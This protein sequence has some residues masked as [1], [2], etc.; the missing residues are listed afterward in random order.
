MLSG[1]IGIQR[2]S[3]NNPISGADNAPQNPLY[4]RVQVETV[5][6]VEP[7]TVDEMNSFLKL[8]G[9]AQNDYVR[10]LIVAARQACETYTGVK[11]VTQTLNAWYDRIP[12]DSTLKLLYGPCQ[13][14]TSVTTYASDGT[15]TVFDEDSYFK[16]IISSS[17][18]IILVD[19]QTWPVNTRS[20]NAVRVVYVVGYGLAANVPEAI[21]TAI[22]LV[23]AAIFETPG[24][25][26]KTK[27]N[28]NEYMTEGIKF[29]LTPYT[30]VSL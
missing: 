29:M 2:Y 19:G 10:G 5:P 13:S 26:K 20:Y 7:V 18:R 28:V 16:D 22:K 8:N 27:I 15:A 14:I 24:E 6:A 30:K 23:V 12:Y 9:E 21:K 17:P 4:G 3:G 1:D 25:I 11:F